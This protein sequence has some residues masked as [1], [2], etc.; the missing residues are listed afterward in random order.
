ML[1][2]AMWAQLIDLE[3]ALSDQDSA[4]YYP[5]ISQWIRQVH[6][7]VVE[8]MRKNVTEAQR[9]RSDENDVAHWQSSTNAGCSLACR[10]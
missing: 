6:M 7:L 4:G 2:P 1:P 8:V 9:I 5:G 3:R 10:E